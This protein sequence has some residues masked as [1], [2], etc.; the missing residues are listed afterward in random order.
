MSENP[1]KCEPPEFDP[2]NVLGYYTMRYRKPVP[3]RNLFKWAKAFEKSNRRVRKTYINDYYI[4][5][6]F[7]G[8][9]HNFSGDEPLLFETMIFSTADKI[10]ALG[11]DFDADTGYQSRCSTWR[12]ALKMHWAAVDYIKRVPRGTTESRP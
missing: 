6:V 10:L 9:E 7:L 2:E 3:C 8:L 5:T 4:S 11:R 12:Q 1:P